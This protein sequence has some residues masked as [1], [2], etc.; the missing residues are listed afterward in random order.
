[1]FMA[2]TAAVK[3]GM[4]VIVVEPVF[5]LV[6]II[7]MAGAIP[8]PLVTTAREEYQLDPQAVIDAIND[9]TCAIMLNSPGNPT[10][11]IYPPETIRAI[12][13]AAAERGLALISDEVYECLILDDVDYRKRSDLLPVAGSCDR[14][15]QRVQ[16]LLHGRSA[17]GMGHLQRPEHPGTFSAT[18]CSSAPPRTRL[19][20][21]PS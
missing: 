15:Q 18:T 6:H 11:A 9:R 4:E 1:M 21:G 20:S 2:L 3:P 17:P 10:G 13:E 16:D 14:G 8:R 12:S 19:P 7:R 5:I